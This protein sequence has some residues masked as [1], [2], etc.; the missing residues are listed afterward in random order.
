MLLVNVL[1]MF[2]PHFPKTSWRLFCKT[3]SRCLE[4]VLERHLENVL[5]TSW[6]CI[7]RTNI[8]VLIKTFWRRLLKTKTWD[9]SSRPLQDIFIKAN[10]C[11]V[12]ISL[13]CYFFELTLA[14]S[15]VFVWLDSRNTRVMLVPFDDWSQLIYIRCGNFTHVI[16]NDT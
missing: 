14:L 15:I 11:W 2:W 1:K 4:D 8:F 10:V 16:F 5:K 7:I 9:V 6:R 13:K 3:S 12:V